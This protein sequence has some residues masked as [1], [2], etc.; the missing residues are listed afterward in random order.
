M[1]PPNTGV[2]AFRFGACVSLVSRPFPSWVPGAGRKLGTSAFAAPEWL[3]PQTAESSK[4]EEL[5]FV[6]SVWVGRCEPEALL[7]V[8]E[9]A[10]NFDV[11]KKLKLV[12]EPGTPASQQTIVESVNGFSRGCR[13]RRVEWRSLKSK[14]R[15]TRTSDRCLNGFS[16]GPSR[17]SGTRLLS[18]TCSVQIW[19]CN[20]FYSLQLQL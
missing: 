14:G 17:S 19:R 6:Q 20:F 4:Y 11:K 18:R 5:V 1:V 15:D 10:P 16:W 2:L 13:W 8:L 3:E 12:G 9:A 7:Q